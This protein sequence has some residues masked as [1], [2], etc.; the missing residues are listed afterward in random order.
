MR[1]E[2]HPLAPR[3]AGLEG[4]SNVTVNTPAIVVALGVMLMSLPSLRMAVS[5]EARASSGSQSPSRAGLTADDRDRV[6]AMLRDGRYA[7]AEAAA[8]KILADVEAHAGRDGLDTA[9]VLDLLVECLWRGGS[10]ESQEATVLAE[11]AVQIK[12][13]T[14]G[15]RHL[16]L[17]RSL[18]NQAALFRMT[19]RYEEAK[20]L[21]ERAV[22]ITEKSLG[23][24]HPD[25]ARPVYNL[26]CLLMDMSRFSEAKPLFARALRLTEK[27]LGPDHLNVAVILNAYANLLTVTG[28]YAAAKSGYERVVSI[29]EKG[30]GP[31]HH[32]VASSLNNLAYLLWNMGDFTG[33]RSQYERALAGREAVLGAEHP[34][35]AQTLHNLGRLM[36]DTGDYREAGVLFERALVIRETVLGTQHPEVADTLESLGVLAQVRGDRDHARALHERSLRIREASLGSGSSDVASSLDSLA[37][38]LWEGGGRQKARELAERALAVR[39]KTLGASHPEVAESLRNLAR[40]LE[41]AEPSERAASLYV[42]ALAIQ[43]GALGPRHPA[44]AVTLVDYAGLLAAAGQASRA[45]D[46]ALQ[47]EAVSREHIRLTVRTLA[48]RQALRYLAV[49]AA[50]LDLVLSLAGSDLRT[51]D[52]VAGRAWDSLIRSRALVLDE[53]AARHAV[54]EPSRDQGI[55]HLVQDVSTTRERLAHLV[56]RGATREHAEGYRR[57][58]DE[59]RN[60][61]ERAERAL[62]E[63]SLGF[64]EALD[65]Q[66]V[67]LKEVAA[68]LP[69]RSAVVA[70]ALHDGADAGVSHPG[71]LAFILPTGGQRPRLVPLGPASEIG[72]LVSRW[73]RIVTRGAAM[74]SRKQQPD[75]TDHRAAGKALRQRIWDPLAGSLGSPDRVFIVPDG[76]LHLLDFS[77][78][79]VGDSGYLVESGPLIHYLSA[80]RDLVYLGAPGRRGVGLLAVG[81]PAFDAVSSVAALERS[82]DSSRHRE[83]DHA[84]RGASRGEQSGCG[85]FA[86]HRFEPLPASASEAEYVASAWKRSGLMTNAANRVPAETDFTSL[87]EVMLLQ[88]VEASEAAIKEMAPGRRVLHLATHGF[89]LA[90][91][92]NS[93]L[94]PSRGI[95]G[96]ALAPADR[97]LVPR[98]ENPLLLS[99]LALGGANHR[100]D[101]GPEEE[102]GILTAEEI[103]ALPLAGVEWAVLSG[104]DTGLGEVNAGEGVLGLRRAFHIAGARTV[105]MSLWAVGDEPARDW[106]Q[107]LYSARLIDR[108]DT[109]Q[110]VRRAN[111]TMLR[112]LR[113]Q[114]SEPHP[115]RW[116][117]FVAAG[118]WR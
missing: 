103:A 88:G 86:S 12:E 96:L 99:G 105:I 59:A 53:M 45:F 81:G 112:R 85:R 22:T 87:A 49:K 64:R 56:V 28:D 46:L 84:Q 67:G 24:E 18:Q 108:L 4:S 40:F 39:E 10:P 98:V 51:T 33:A 78:L 116:A 42:R 1:G 109:P 95:G 106:M 68:S 63:K 107:E 35:V 65:K 71:Y 82:G 44:V 20:P 26:A 94:M 69:P 89:F 25:M 47:A 80:E 15:P 13:K 16:E 2:D 34:L 118:D 110:A 114:G 92:C 73:R 102:D 76:V 75:E 113:E 48:E 11:R 60:E 31:E 29:R 100:A 23:A 74:E 97:A 21:Y 93:G 17:A 72:D 9:L 37:G 38:L 101:A 6:R 77:A 30:L 41:G 104:C 66:R 36:L 52:G 83:E 91:E 61:A 90:G 8:R 5:R 79:P 50:G 27:T 3:R 7:E 19:A 32:E 58:L 54:A 115:L 57:L 62:A 43:E 111:L 55:A 70:F 117:G 14:L